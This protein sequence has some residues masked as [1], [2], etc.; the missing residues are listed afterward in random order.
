MQTE[1]KPQPRWTR[2]KD[3]R[4]GELLEAALDLF[5]ER[6]FAA[7]RL[8][9]VARRAG[10]SKGTLYLY[11]SGKEELF[12]AVVR[13]SLLPKLV[14]AEETL[15]NKVADSID[16]FRYL[17][18]TWWDQIGNTRLAG[19]SRLVL[20]ESA[21]FPELAEFY[22]KEFIARGMGMFESL[23][24]R[25]IERGEIRKVDAH[26]ITQVIMA[27]LM[28]LMMWKHSFGA[29]KIEPISPETFLNSMVDLCMNGLAVQKA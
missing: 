6:G 12:K 10:V 8:E 29:T 26:H 20:L 17:I 16:Q 28:M 22:H 19:L 2:R 3:A 5:V 25:G 14:A 21:H 4:P 15:K 18:Q 9:D 11:F 1:N 7:T 23:L 27:P 24:R 13:E